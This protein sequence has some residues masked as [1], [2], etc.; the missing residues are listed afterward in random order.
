MIMISASSIIS[1]SCPLNPTMSTHWTA[2]TSTY[3]QPAS[4]SQV[5]EKL[6]PSHSQNSKKGLCNRLRD[7]FCCC[8][9]HTKKSNTSE[10]KAKTQ[11]NL[12]VPHHKTEKEIDTS[13][14]KE[15][16]QNEKLSTGK[17]RLAWDCMGICAEAG[18]VTCNLLSALS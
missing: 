16:R 15:K 9:P 8:R 7:F 6:Q 13:A 11:G 4:I 12:N 10:N 5:S 14:A 3:C 17:N 18:A 1:S 2:T